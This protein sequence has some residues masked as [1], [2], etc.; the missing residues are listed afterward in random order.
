MLTL[1]QPSYDLEGS[2]PCPPTS[3]RWLRQLPLGKP[4]R[5]EGCPADAPKARLRASLTRYGAKAG[6]VW[7][8]GWASHGAPQEFHPL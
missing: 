2:G 8:Y 6:S 4:Y 7:R 1:N 5:S 3:L